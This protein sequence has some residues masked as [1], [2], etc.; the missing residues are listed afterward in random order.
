MK[1]R[2]SVDRIVYTVVTTGGGVDG[3]D[4]TDK[5]GLIVLATFNKEEAVKRIGLDCRFKLVPT[6]VD[7]DDA[8]RSVRA[9]LTTYDRSILSAA[10]EAGEW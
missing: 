8:I 3:M 10:I 5:G 6:V 1:S 9:K 4:H 2:V 7:M